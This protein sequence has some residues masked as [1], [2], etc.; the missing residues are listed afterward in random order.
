MIKLFNKPIDGFIEGLKD[1]YQ[2]GKLIIWGTGVI[3]CR[4]YEFF[5]YL[6]VKPFAYCDNNRELSKNGTLVNGLHVLSPEE[7]KTMVDNG[8]DVL[9]QIAFYQTNEDGFYEQ[10]ED[11]GVEKYITHREN[12]GLPQY[13]LD[14]KANE[15]HFPNKNK[16]Y[17]NKTWLV[18]AF[19]KKI[20]IVEKNT[21]ENGDNFVSI[22]NP[23]KTGDITLMITLGNNAYMTGHMPEVFSSPKF[24]KSDKK[25]KVI[26]AVREPIGHTLSN[27]YQELEYSY[28]Y[29]LYNKYGENIITDGGDVQKIFN[30]YLGYS[31]MDISHKNQA[32]IKTQIPNFLK[33]FSDN[34]L[35]VMSVPFDKEKGCTIIKD[36]NI[37]VFVYTLEKM[38]DIIPEMSEF[39]GKK[40]DKWEMGNVAADKW[41]GES[42]KQAQK[43]LKFSQEYFDI[44]YS[45]PYVKHFYSDEQIEK[46]KDKWR[47]NIK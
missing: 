30:M 11:L 22:C 2:D 13:I 23:P 25:I 3:G 20:E 21:I 28:M 5:E 26:T 8:E 27:L 14:D 24:A 18:D 45:Q 6:G 37:E 34:V 10:L 39:V 42:Y 16:I 32:Q 4:V 19:D 35:D 33:R 7:L 1:L 9:V 31:T 40:F 38:N 36:G 44:C 46:F 47:K 15:Y 17:G 12:F 29:F 43:E 41:V